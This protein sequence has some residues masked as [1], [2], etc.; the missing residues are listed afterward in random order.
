MRTERGSNKLNQ[1]HMSSK[2]NSCQ[3]YRIRPCSQESSDA[4]KD[5]G[6]RVENQCDM[7]L[8]EHSCGE[9]KQT[10]KMLSPSKC[11]KE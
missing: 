5:I 1:S 6:L 2:W 8:P 9:K 10:T 11:K 7:R 3:G 4:E